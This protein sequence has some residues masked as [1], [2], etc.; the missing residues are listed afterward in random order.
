[1][2]LLDWCFKCCKRK[3]TDRK[4]S[5]EH[6]SEEHTDKLPWSVLAVEST[7]F[8]RL[9]RLEPTQNTQKK[10]EIKSL[11]DSWVR[12]KKLQKEKKKKKGFF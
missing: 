10:M 4:G 2:L 6:E 5:K 9:N 12:E 8:L 7:A 11:Y 3:E 1:M